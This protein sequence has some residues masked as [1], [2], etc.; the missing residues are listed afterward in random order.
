MAASQRS[1]GEESTKVTA[2]EA[3]LDR[4]ERELASVIEQYER[5]ID[6]RARLR[7]ETRPDETFVWTGES[8]S[9]P[10]E[11]GRLTAF[12]NRLR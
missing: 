11:S 2:L 9:E 7:R 12:L 5:V 8:D 10:E 6:T 4:K 3:E 1:P